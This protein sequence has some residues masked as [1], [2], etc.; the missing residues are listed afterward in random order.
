MLDNEVIE[1]KNEIFEIFLSKSLK[2]LTD[3]L[4]TIIDD[5]LTDR[6][7]IRATKQIIVEIICH[8]LKSPE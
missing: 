2:K 4:I 7:K 6:Y 5:E 1:K 8:C 3:Y